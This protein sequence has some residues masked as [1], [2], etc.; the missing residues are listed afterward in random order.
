MPGGYEEEER[1]QSIEGEEVGGSGRGGGEVL[2]D[3]RR[4]GVMREE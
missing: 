3:W 1:G 4:E 2:S